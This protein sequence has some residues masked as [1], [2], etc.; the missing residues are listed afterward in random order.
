MIAYCPEEVRMTVW[1][2]FFSLYPSHPVSV[3]GIIS[4]AECY[5]LGDAI[6]GAPDPRIGK[7]W[8]G[9]QCHSYQVPK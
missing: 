8:A 5:R 7:H 6:K 1:V 4:E 2:L 3:P 9:M